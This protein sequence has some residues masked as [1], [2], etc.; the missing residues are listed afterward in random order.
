MAYNKVIYK[1]EVLVDLTQDS[2]TAETLAV[3]ATAHDKSGEVIVGTFEGN[4]GID[5]SDATATASDILSGKTAYV[6]G[7]KIT[8]TIATVTQATPTVSID[9][10]GKITASTTQ[11]A[12]YVGAGT[13]TGTKQLTTQAAKTITPSTS[14]QTAVASGRYTTGAVTVAAIPSAYIQPSGTKTIT[15]NGTHDVKSYASA[16]VNVA[17]EDVT[18]E[19]TAYTNKL[20]SLETAITALET[21]LAGKASG[22]GSGG[23][24]MCTVNLSST[25]V[26]GMYLMRFCYM[27]PNLPNGYDVF[28]LVISPGVS[29]AEITVLRNSIFVIANWPTSVGSNINDIDNLTE[30]EN[31]AYWITGDCS[32]DFYVSAGGTDPA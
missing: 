16:T 8:G 22:G 3:G 23:L 17:G 32:I 12:G 28:E 19:T 21:E 31:R 13:K 20:A 29:S 18:T 14:S 26:S 10:N 9:A 30:I 7:E 27:N 2:V 15:T 24:E 5:T 1:G 11:S 4:N 25:C 6:D